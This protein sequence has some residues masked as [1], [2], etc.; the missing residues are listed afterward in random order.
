M[1]W[2]KHHE[3]ILT[4]QLYQYYPIV[5]WVV[6]RDDVYLILQDSG[7]GWVVVAYREG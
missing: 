6:S 1:K 4:G 3:L 5:E 2:P 7:C